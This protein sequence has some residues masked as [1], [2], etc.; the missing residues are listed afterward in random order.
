M[1]KSSPRREPDVPAELL[2]ALFGNVTKPAA[3]LTGGGVLPELTYKAA[4]DAFGAH[5]AAERE[6][7]AE[8]LGQR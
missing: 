8:L 7:V 4:V 5:G 1:K 2:R 3:A 6:P